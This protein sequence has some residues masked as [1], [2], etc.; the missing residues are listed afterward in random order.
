MTKASWISLGDFIANI[1]AA[2]R[3][4]DGRQGLALA[5]A[6]LIAQQ[7][8]DNCADADANRAILCNRGRL[9][10]CGC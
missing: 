6:Y 5:S 10:V 1:P 4:G 7:P 3:S 8:A 9:L 2:H